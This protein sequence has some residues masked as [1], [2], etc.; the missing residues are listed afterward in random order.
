V[1]TALVAL[2]LFVVQP[3]VTAVFKRAGQGFV[4]MAE[5]MTPTVPRYDYVMVDKTSTTRRRGEVIAFERDVRGRRQVFIFRVIGLPGDRVAVRGGHA[6]VN[7]VAT[8]EPYAI[9]HGTPTGDVGV[10]TVPTQHLFVLGDNRH[11]ALDS[12]VWGF[13]PEQDVI[14]RVYV[15]YFS[16]EPYTGAIRWERIGQPVR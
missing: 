11:N 6:V 2:F 5:S 13:L 1:W 12:R 3:A 7:D 8:A 9:V 15:V 10:V 14:G 4:F 16:Q